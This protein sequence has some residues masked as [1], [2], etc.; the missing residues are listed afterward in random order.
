MDVPS[1]SRSW[2]ALFPPPGILFPA[3]IPH[4]GLRKPDFSL[5]FGPFSPPNLYP[6]CPP[7]PQPIEES[8]GRGLDSKSQKAL[9]FPWVGPGLP[10]RVL[11][12]GGA[13]NFQILALSGRGGDCW[14]QT[15]HPKPHP[16]PPSPRSG[17]PEEMSCPLHG[18][19]RRDT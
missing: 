1:A 16:A 11:S 9:R 18:L 7:R 5:E 6:E 13:G 3:L 4:P 12:L 14:A 19:T 8:G 17:H 15:P 2:P 10:L